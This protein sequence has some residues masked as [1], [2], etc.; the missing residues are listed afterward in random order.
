M[1]NDKIIMRYPIKKYAQA[2]YESTV[3]KSEHEQEKISKAFVA[4]LAAYNDSSLL[5]RIIEYYSRVRR[6]SE[7]LTKVDL[8]TADKASVKIK[9]ELK[10]KLGERLE[11]D[12][13]IDPNVLG[14]IKLIINDEYLIDGTFQS[15]VER[16]HQALVKAND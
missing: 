1:T 12:E 2:L 5:S 13:K 16:L 6:R 7:G 4:L 11:I 3:G 14:G 10:K 15:R 9:T 8:T